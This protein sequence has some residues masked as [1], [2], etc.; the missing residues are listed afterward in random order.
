MILKASIRLKRQTWTIGS[1]LVTVVLAAACMRAS[2]LCAESSSVSTII[3][4]GHTSYYVNP[5]TGNDDNS[6]L[7]EDQAWRSFNPVNARTFKPSDRIQIIES[8]SFHESLIIHCGGSKEEPLEIDFAKGRYDFYPAN[9]VKLKLNISNNNDT[10]DI[11]KAVAMLFQ[12]AE[13]IRV[14]GNSSDF[15]IHGMMIETM[16][17]NDV[18]IVMDGLNFDY[19]RP[20]VS[21]FKVMC[22]QPNYA[23]IQVQRDSTYRIENGSL[24]W[25]GEGWVSSGLGLSQE[26]NPAGGLLWRRSSPLTGITKVKEIAPFKLRLYFD[27]NPGLIAGNVLQFREITR[28]YVGV[29]IQHSRDITWKDSSFYFMHGMGIVSQ[30]GENLSFEN[31]NLTPRPNSG[32]TCAGWADMFHF[33]DCRGYIEI[34]GCS[35]AGM[36]DDAV[37]VHGVY[38]RVVGHPSANQLLVEFMHPQT[39]GFN[40]F[41]AGDNIELVNSKSLYAYHSNVVLQS[42]MTDPKHILLTLANP[43]PEKIGKNDAVENTTWTPSVEIQGCNVSLDSCRGFLLTTRRRVVVEGN[44]FKRT[45]MSAILISDDANS[46]FESGPVKDVLIASNRFIECAEPVIAISPE[47]ASVNPSQPVHQNIRIVDNYFGLTG[48]KA[49]SAKSVNDLVIRGNSFSSSILPV[50]TT[51]CTRVSLVQNKLDVNANTSKLSQNIENIQK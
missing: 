12:G 30:F 21:E 25:V 9:S 37:N 46:W 24:I 10:P 20:T 44:I 33:C 38:L 5:K 47:N 32:R 41:F 22:I 26:C 39:Y 49:I 7:V 13:N 40:A 50:Q 23:D 1:F 51:A 18:N 15:Y 16:L 11:P 3:S 42:E 28:G 43:I 4:P 34:N 2:H 17:D 29:F 36:N 14:N 19:Q 45:D 48:T 27:N 8:G 31:D 35:M 6:G